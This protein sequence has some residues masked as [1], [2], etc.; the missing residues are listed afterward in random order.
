MLFKLISKVSVMKN[1]SIIVLSLLSLMHMQVVFSADSSGFSLKDGLV[2]GYGLWHLSSENASLAQQIELLKKEKKVLDD[3]VK[4]SEVRISHLESIVG[5]GSF[6][7]IGGM[8]EDDSLTI[9]IAKLLRDIDMMQKEL[10]SREEEKN[11]ASLRIAES[12]MVS[13]QLPRISRQESENAEAVLILQAQ[14]DELTK[15]GILKGKYKELDL[16][17]LLAHLTV[18]LSTLEREINSLRTKI[19]HPIPGTIKPGTLEDQT[20]NELEKMRKMYDCLLQKVDYQA[21]AL[22]TSLSLVETLKRK[23]STMDV[24]EDE[25]GDGMH[26]KLSSNEGCSDDEVCASTSAICAE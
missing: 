13:I 12:P 1:K 10:L 20:K 8:Q 25:S 19:E 5:S 24:M 14:L 15:P 21:R 18:R 9:A 3:S 7:G 11:C 17:T 4:E 22:D 16:K 23:L 26:I 6:G 2:V